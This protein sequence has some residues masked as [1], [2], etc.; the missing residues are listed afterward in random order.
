MKI[1]FIFSLFSVLI[2]AAE[3]GKSVP[4]VD[5]FPVTADDWAYMAKYHENFSD[6]QRTRAAYM[7]LAMKLDEICN[8]G[9]VEKI[10]AV[11]NNDG[12]FWG[13]AWKNWSNNNTENRKVLDIIIATLDNLEPRQ[14]T[15]PVKRTFK[16]W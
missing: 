1:A 15:P 7:A 8:C 14:Y 2:L 6:N 13:D 12:R 9:T 11:S 3:D 10:K 16:G 5:Y 4:G